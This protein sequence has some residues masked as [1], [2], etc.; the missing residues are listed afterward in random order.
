MK[1]IKFFFALLL[2]TLFIVS[3]CS[4]EKRVHRSGYHVAWKNSQSN[5]QK[6]D[7]EQ[8]LAVDHISQEESQNVEKISKLKSKEIR[9]ETQGNKL[10][11]TDET[12]SVAVKKETESKTTKLHIS[13][14]SSNDQR[15]IVNE[16][17]EMPSSTEVQHTQ[18]S[19]NNSNG[20]G[21]VMFILLVILCLIIPPLAVY[22]ITEDLKL[23]LISLILTLLFWL[24]GVIFAFYILFTRY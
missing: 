16:A 24:P 1:N 22:L 3:S 23:T 17:L 19:N 14:N 2:P 6:L 11:S 15:A 10:I 4:I 18:E 7:K 8:L 12:K 13:N 5:H 9:Y 20:L 21:D